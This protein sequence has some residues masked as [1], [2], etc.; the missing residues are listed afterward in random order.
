MHFGAKVTVYKKQ[1]KCTCQYQIVGVDEADFNKNKISFLSPMA[2]VLL[3]KKVGDTTVFK[4]PIG[5]RVMTIKTIEYE[6]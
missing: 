5:Q 6:K 2:K 1:E 4:T 3:N